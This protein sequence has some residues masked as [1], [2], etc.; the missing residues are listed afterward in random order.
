[1]A[2]RIEGGKIGGEMAFFFFGGRRDFKSPQSF[3][4]K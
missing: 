1:V 4:E 2:R 3:H